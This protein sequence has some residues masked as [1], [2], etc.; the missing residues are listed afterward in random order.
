MIEEIAKMNDTPENILK[1]FMQEHFPFTEFRKVGF[2]TKEMKGD[3]Q[4]QADRVCNHFGHK[5]VFE[6][7]SKDIHCHISYADGKRPEGE[8]FITDVKN[9]YD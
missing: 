3:Y 7:G 2:F 8:G 1:R 5:T 6:Y 4:A 9:I